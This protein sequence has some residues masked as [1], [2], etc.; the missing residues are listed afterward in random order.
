MTCIGRTWLIRR[1]NDDP[2]SFIKRNWHHLRDILEHC[3][4]ISQTSPLFFNARAVDRVRTLGERRNLSFNE[5]ITKPL[6]NTMLLSH[7]NYLPNDK[8]PPGNVGGW[9]LW[10]VLGTAGFGSL[11]CFR[12]EELSVPVLCGKNNNNSETKNHRFCLFRKTQWM[13]VFMK[14]PEKN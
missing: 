8:C 2:W 11:K 13:T 3:R 6:K 5:Q 4:T 1:G 12:I 7:H 9:V 10:I 14:E